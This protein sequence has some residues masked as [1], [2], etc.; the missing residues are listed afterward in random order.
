[1]PNGLLG[2]IKGGKISDQLS[3]CERLKKALLH[4]VGFSA[5]Q[6]ITSIL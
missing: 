6:E 1:M 2:N 5:G 4:G 3:D